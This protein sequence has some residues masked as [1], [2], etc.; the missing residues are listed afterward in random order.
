VLLWTVYLA[1]EPFVRRYWPRVLVS[2]TSVLTGRG[3][4]DVVGRDGGEA[5]CIHLPLVRL[6]SGGK[7]DYPGLFL[8]EQWN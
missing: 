7:C 8:E 4:D 3:S 6:C 5:I 1:L 2:W